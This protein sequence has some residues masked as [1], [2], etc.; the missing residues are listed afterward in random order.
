MTT[1]R[2]RGLT[3]VLP[4]PTEIG[5]GRLAVARPAPPVP[6]VADADEHGR[7]GPAARHRVDP[8]RGWSEA[9]KN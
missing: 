9:A 7:V 4:V 1:L 6:A 3:S 2:T 5:P 8:D